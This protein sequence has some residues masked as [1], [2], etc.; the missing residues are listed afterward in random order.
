MA[1]KRIMIAII[2]LAWVSLACSAVSQPV[3]KSQ[4]PGALRGCE[5]LTA[6]IPFVQ[7]AYKTEQLK[8]WCGYK[9]NQDYDSVVSFYKSQLTANGWKEFRTVQ[10]KSELGAVTN[11]YR[12]KAGRKLSVGIFFM[13][14]M[15][16]KDII[17]ALYPEHWIDQPCGDLDLPTPEDIPLVEN[18]I[19]LCMEEYPGA[20]T[21]KAYYNLQYTTVEN[22]ETVEQFYRTEAVKAGWTLDR[23]STHETA[24]ELVF[25]K[26]GRTASVPTTGK[27]LTEALL[28]TMHVQITSAK[29]YGDT[30]I[31]IRI[32]NKP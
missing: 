31:T 15:G 21:G 7:D 22:F 3:E 1:A 19:G 26:P 13:S 32:D 18:M 17:V 23:E 8:G 24:L 27:K 28:E 2:V 9:T 10:N 6:D 30:D 25:R 20:A 16:A 11:F 4:A 5:F 14:G 29:E 12:E